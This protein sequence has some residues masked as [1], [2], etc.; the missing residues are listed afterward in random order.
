MAEDV[1]SAVADV[2]GVA[3]AAGPAEVVDAEDVAVAVAVAVEVGS[4][5][6]IRE[7]MNRWI[8]E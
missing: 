1:G 8:A 3:D 4:I 7:S 5:E 6:W 2:D